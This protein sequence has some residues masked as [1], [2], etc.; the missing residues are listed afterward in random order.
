MLNRT[1]F[2]LIAVGKIRPA[3]FTHMSM[4]ID[5]KIISKAG[6][7]L[8]M[9]SQHEFLL[10]WL[11]FLLTKGF[12]HTE[13]KA[14]FKVILLILPLWRWSPSNRAETSDYVFEL[15]SYHRQCV[16]LIITKL[17]K[18]FCGKIMFCCSVEELDIIYI[19]LE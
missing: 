3:C 18:S 11:E 7:I 9:H 14:I 19:F 5:N 1:L 2:T 10:D 15:S 12:A 8:C 4:I 13:N 6:S 16:G 17:M